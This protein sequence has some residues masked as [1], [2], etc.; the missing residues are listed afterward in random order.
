MGVRLGN[1]P[2]SILS[3]KA[4][5]I[6]GR[7]PAKT[8]IHLLPLLRKARKQGAQLILVDP[9]RTK[10]AFVCDEHVAPRPGS[11][12]FLAIGMAKELLEM[13]LVDPDS[14]SGG[15]IATRIEGFLEMLDSQK[16]SNCFL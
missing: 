9:I 5:I 14:S 13:D 8:S 3:S 4:I 2:E 12:G 6:W 10:T 11:D 16:Q 7:D 1:D 15:Q